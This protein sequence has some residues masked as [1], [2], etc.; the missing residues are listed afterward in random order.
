MAAGLGDVA[1]LGEGVPTWPQREL[2]GGGAGL[3]AGFFK[4]GNGTLVAQGEKTTFALVVGKLPK[5]EIRKIDLVNG[6]ALHGL[7]VGKS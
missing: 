6:K 4:E 5:G 3:G 2:D 1:V 7:H